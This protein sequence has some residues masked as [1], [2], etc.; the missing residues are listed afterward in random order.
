MNKTKIFS[1]NRVYIQ[2]VKIQTTN[3]K[4]NDF[5]IIIT[6]AR[7]KIKAEQ[8]EG[9]RQ[10]WSGTGQFQLIEWIREVSLR[11]QDSCALNA[12]K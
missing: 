4:G 6:K 9:S 5:C 12:S 8:G 2:V 10:S 3:K 1:F 11:R 7:E